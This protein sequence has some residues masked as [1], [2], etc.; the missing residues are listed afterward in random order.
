MTM[1]SA[2]NAMSVPPDIAYRD[3]PRPALRLEAA[4]RVDAQ[5]LQQALLQQRDKDLKQKQDVDDGQEVLHGLS[6]WARC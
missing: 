6:P 2:A 4:D 5:T 1:P 3:H